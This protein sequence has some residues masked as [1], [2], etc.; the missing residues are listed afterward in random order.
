MTKC[1]LSIQL[2][3]P[4][5]VQ[6]GGGAIHG[7]V[8]VD[9]D[10]D[11][12]CNGL[13]VRSIWKTHGRGNVASGTAGEAVLFSGAWRG[14][15]EQTYRFELPIAAW[16]PSYHGHYLNIDHYVEAQAQIPWAFD[17]KASVPFLMIPAAGQAAPQQD[18]NATGVSGVIGCA[19]GL[20]IAVF[21]LG[22][23][24]FLGAALLQNPIGLL[25]SVALPVLGGLYWLFKVFLPRYLLG[26]VH[27][28]LHRD[29]ISPGESVEGVLAIRPRRNVSINGITA[30]FR[31][32][33]KVVSG[34]GSNRTTHTHVLLE[35]NEVLQ[36]A[37]TLQAG[38]KNEFPFTVAVPAD[39][40]FTLELTDNDLKWTAELRVEIARWPDWT[41]HLELV[42]VPATVPDSEQMEQDVSSPS[43]DDEI[44]FAETAGHFWKV[45]DDNQQA[46]RLAAAVTGLTFDLQAKIERRLL[47]SGDTEPQLGRDYYAVWAR[48]TDPALPLV[49]YVPHDRGD[50]FE[51]L[52]RGG[53]HGRGTVLGWDSQ[54][55]RLQLQIES[56]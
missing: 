15:E 50:E 11:M 3:D 29:I 37:T 20:V 1:D 27:H 19:L 16:P 55:R 39:S 21:V 8:R 53:W 51:Q 32:T 24:G 36:E 33:E 2:D 35:Q 42:V 25:F 34:S 49:L 14:G 22:V 26:D 54:H 18:S 45:R 5:A 17:A 40:P 46:E 31:A 52:G 44:T 13:V 30:S 56:E 7:E 38:M 43:V 41:K 12:Q 23:F 28:E 6:R 4:Q 9:A 47:Y 10:A 48:Y